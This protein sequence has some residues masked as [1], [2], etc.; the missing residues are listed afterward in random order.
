MK[1]KKQKGYKIGISKQNEVPKSLDFSTE[2]KHG[3]FYTERAT[4]WQ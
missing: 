4:S 3:K 1:K 2:V